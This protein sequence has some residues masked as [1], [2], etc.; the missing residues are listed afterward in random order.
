MFVT[1]LAIKPLIAGA[2]VS[3]F[4]AFA[5]FAAVV[6]ASKILAA[7]PSVTLLAHAHS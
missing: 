2:F 4:V 7:W 3:F 5:M 1:S 6:G